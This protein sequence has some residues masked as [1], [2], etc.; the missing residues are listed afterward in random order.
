MSDIKYIT[1]P[2]C[3]VDGDFITVARHPGYDGASIEIEISVTADGHE[4]TVLL[5]PGAVAVIVAAFA[6]CMDES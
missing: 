2:C 5:S 4:S 1:I 3:E 6:E